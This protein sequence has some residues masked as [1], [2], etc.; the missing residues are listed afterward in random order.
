MSSSSAV[1]L[2]SNPETFRLKTVNLDRIRERK[3]PPPLPPRQK[4]N[5]VIGLL[6]SLLSSNSKSNLEDIEER[7][8]QTFRRYPENN[9]A[10]W[11]GDISM[12]EREEVYCKASDSKLYI[13]LKKVG[14]GSQSAVWLAKNLTTGKNVCIKLFEGQVDKKAVERETLIHHL[15]GTEKGAPLLSPKAT[16]TSRNGVVI[17]WIDGRNM[18]IVMKDEYSKFSP[19]DL[20]LQA[21]ELVKVLHRKGYLFWF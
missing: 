12:P 13:L 10:S 17:K 3:E 18:S 1:K 14:R 16:K 15:L 21:K 11:S 8:R 9:I 20:Y 4:T 5:K 19:M 6:N 7:A 2:V